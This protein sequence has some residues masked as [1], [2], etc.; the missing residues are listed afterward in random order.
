[1]L[2]DFKKAFFWPFFKINVHCAGA[3]F[4]IGRKKKPALCKSAGFF[5]RVGK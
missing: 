1:M 4:Y 3:V 2:I 5:V